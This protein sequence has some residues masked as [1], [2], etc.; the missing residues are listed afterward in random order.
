MAVSRQSFMHDHASKTHCTL[1][2]RKDH[3]LTLRLVSTTNFA[4]NPMPQT[5]IPFMQFRGGSSKGIYFLANDLP[6][7]ADLRDQIIL[8]AVGSDASQVDGLGGGVP[9][10]S[11]VAIVSSSEQ[12]GVDVDYLFVQVVVGENRVDKKPN[13][14]NIL[15]G[16][17]PFALEAGL[18]K[19]AGDETRVVVRMLNSDKL[20]DLVL[21]TP[22]KQVTYSGDAQIDGVQ[23]SAAPITCLYSDLAGSVTG[24]LLPTGNAVDIVD[25]IE[26]TCIDNG[27]PVVV[28]RA[29]DLGISGYESPQALDSDSALKEKLESIRKQIGPKMN[30]GNVEGA[31]VPKMCLVSAA[32][33]GGLI[34]TRAFIPYECHKS[35]GVLGAVSVATACLLPESNVY[36]MANPVPG[37]FQSVEHPAGAFAISLDVDKTKTPVAVNS[38]GVLRTARLLSRGELFVPQNT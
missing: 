15:A 31:A 1:K 22:N 26:I 17:G 16:V 9:L 27:M 38:A 7:D 13:C 6:S 23:G 5:T 4:L 32:K 33:N 8:D 36:Q 12:E 35:I 34:N 11:K 3:T 37:S 14:G 25:G 20:C 10:T 19:P 28:L 21:Q 18:V 24:A 29:T 2:G 30:L